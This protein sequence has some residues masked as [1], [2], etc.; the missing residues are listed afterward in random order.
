MID[1]GD[2][3]KEKRERFEIL[4][5]SRATFHEPF[6][7]RELLEA[8]WDHR[9]AQGR[10]RYDQ[11]QEMH[12]LSIDLGDITKDICIDEF[13]YNLKLFGRVYGNFN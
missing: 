12:R 13:C 11:L 7:K 9:S 2:F 4:W 6:E 1:D 3:L 5:N 10:L 8:L